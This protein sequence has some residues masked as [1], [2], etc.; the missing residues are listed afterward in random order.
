[1]QTDTLWNALTVTT[2]DGRTVQVERCAELDCH[3]I[4]TYRI[5]WANDTTYECGAHA[6]DNVP[7][8]ERYL[9]A[10]QSIE[11]AAYWGYSATWHAH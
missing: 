7:R 4:A 8:E 11:Y 3:R 9:G 5:A 2:R 1:M 6:L 10:V